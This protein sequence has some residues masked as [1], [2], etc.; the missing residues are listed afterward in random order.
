MPELP[1]VETVARGLREQIVG[2]RIVSVRLGKT[3]FI[4]DPTVDRVGGT[5]WEIFVDQAS[6]YKYD[7]CDTS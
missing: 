5:I 4:D 1:E 3:D 6:S 7:D 2:R